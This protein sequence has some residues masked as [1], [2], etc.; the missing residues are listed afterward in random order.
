VGEDFVKKIGPF[1]AAL[2]LV[3][4][5]VAII[6]AFTIDLGVPERYVSLHDTEYYMQNTET[7][8]ELLDE[9][10][11]HVFPRLEGITNSYVSPNGDVVV[12]YINEAD[13]EKTRGTIVRDFEDIM[14][15]FQKSGE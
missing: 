4:S 2:V 8:A 15:E 3:L 13:F 7:M 11:E 6:L 9:L 1:G 14:F 12:I 5:A 10:R